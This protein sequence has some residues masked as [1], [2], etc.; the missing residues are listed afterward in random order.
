MINVKIVIA[1]VIEEKPAKVG[2][3]SDICDLFKLLR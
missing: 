3:I 2:G 1:E